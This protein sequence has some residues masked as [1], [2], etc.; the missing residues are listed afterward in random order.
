M[1]NE[2]VIKSMT[3]KELAN[4]LNYHRTMYG[5]ITPFCPL[6]WESWAND[7]EARDVESCSTCFE[8]WLRMDS[9][10]TPKGLLR[11]DVKKYWRVH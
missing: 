5:A 1:T 9:Q 6:C 8:E 10:D 3:V 7:G 11:D 2:E 4:F